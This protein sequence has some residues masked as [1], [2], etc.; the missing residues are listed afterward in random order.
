[1]VRA[2]RCVETHQQVG[3]KD[4]PQLPCEDK[5]GRGRARWPEG[6]L[7]H[8]TRVGAPTFLLWVDNS[9]RRALVRDLPIRDPVRLVRVCAEAA[10]PVR[11]VVLEA[12]LVDH[13]CRST[14][15]SPVRKKNERGLSGRYPT[16]LQLPPPSGR[17][18]DSR[19]RRRHRIQS[20]RRRCLG[21]PDPNRTRPAQ[22]HRHHGGRSCDAEVPRNERIIERE[23]ADVR[24]ARGS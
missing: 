12:A 11:L 21:F 1:M 4:L 8:S 15:E 5:L 9:V 23:L 13:A 16:L 18:R 20:A 2:T 24:A 10:L 7:R 6:R 22:Q 17:D 14:C 3:G 19:L